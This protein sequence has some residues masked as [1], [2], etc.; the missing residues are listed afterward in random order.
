M[1]STTVV[2]MAQAAH[3]HQVRMDSL[4]EAA[5]ASKLALGQWLLL[6]SELFDLA[7]VAIPSAALVL[8]VFIWRTK[9]VGS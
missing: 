6:R 7:Q 5:Q 8:S 1:D 4:R 9:N 2:L 3:L